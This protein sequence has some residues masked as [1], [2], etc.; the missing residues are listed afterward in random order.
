MSLLHDNLQSEND[1]VER[2]ASSSDGFD[3]IGRADIS[4]FNPGNILPEPTAVLGDITSWLK[5]T[6]YDHDGSEF[7]KHR[8]LRLAGTC[9]WVY[10]T[11]VY[12]QWHDGIDP[13]ILWI[14]GAPGSG[15]SVLAASLIEKLSQEECPVLYFF[16][17]HTIAANHSAEAAV[18][19]WLAQVLRFSPPLQVEL[20]KRIKG[21]LGDDAG[22][23]RLSLADAFRLLR[24]ALSHLPEAY[25]L[26]DALDEADQEALEPFL[27]H[28]DELSTWRPQEVKLIMTSRP[29]AVVE[30]IVRG[31][32]VLDVRLDKQRVGSDIAAYIQ[33]R[34]A[35]SSVPTQSRSRV[36]KIIMDRCD[37]LFLY[38]RLAMDHVLKRPYQEM[39]NSLRAIPAGL[40][41]VYSNILEE[42]CR[43]TDIPPGLQQLVLELVTHATRPL[44]LLEI[45]DCINAAR[46][47]GDLGT[48]KSLIRS[49]CGPLLE[50]LPD[51]TVHVIHHSLTEFLNGTVRDLGHST[52]P[53]FEP[54]STHNRLAL[55]CISYLQA[56]CLNSVKVIPEVRLLRRGH[57]QEDQVL[58]SFMRY[59][60]LNWHVHVQ[61][62]MLAGHDQS[63]ANKQIHA[64]FAK[65]SLEKLGRLAED[66][67]TCD[68]TP[69]GLATSFK[70]LSFAREVLCLAKLNPEANKV[71]KEPPLQHAAMNGDV[72]LV[73]LLLEFGADL[74]AY[75]DF[76]EST[77]HLAVRH[78]R[79]QVVRVLLDA[80]ADPFIPNGLNRRIR[81]KPRNDRKTYSP[82]HS[83]F[84]DGDFRIASMFIPYLKTAELANWALVKAVEHQRADILGRLL[85]N[86]MVNV[87]SKLR[88]WTPLCIACTN[89]DADSIDLLL[90]AGADPNILNNKYSRTRTHDEGAKTGRNALHA[91]ADS[92]ELKFTNSMK[93]RDDA[94]TRRCFKLVLDA[95]AKVDL[96]DHKGLTPLHV[97]TD[98]TAVGCLLDA[99]ADPDAINDAGETLLHRTCN[100][101]I[102]RALLPK[103]DID[104]KSQ[105][106]LTPLLA[107]LKELCPK[108]DL[109]LKKVSLLLEFRADATSVDDYGNGALHH[110]VSTSRWGRPDLL[111]LRKL[112]ASGADV[113]LKNHEGQTP[114]HWCLPG[115]WGG[116][117]G[118]RQDAKLLEELLAAGAEPEAKDSKGRTPL[119]QLMHSGSNYD[120]DERIEICE[121]MVAAGARIDT[122]DLEG[123]NLL[124][125]VLQAARPHLNLIRWLVSR[126]IN[127][128][129][130]DARGNTL[131]HLAAPA[132]AKTTLIN[133]PLISELGSLG[134]SPVKTNDN[135]QTPLHIVAGFHPFAFRPGSDRQNERQPHGY[136]A[137]LFDHLVGLYKNVDCVDNDG[138]TPL[139]IASTFSEYLTRRL[140]EKGADPRNKTLEGLTPLH[141][142]ARSRQSNTL[143]I[144]LSW[145]QANMDESTAMELLNARDCL[146][147]SALYY[148]C[149]SGRIETVRMLLDAGAT[150]E[151]ES[152]RGSPW[153]GCVALQDEDTAN[154]RLVSADMNYFNPEPDAAG[155]LI[156]DTLRRKLDVDPENYDW[157][158]PFP[159]ERLDEIIDLLVTHGPAS[160]VR[161]IDEAISWS[162]KKRF[163][164]AVECLLRARDRLGMKDEY[165]LD[166]E[167]CAHLSQRLET[168][169]PS[170]V[171]H[172]KDLAV[173]LM[174]DRRYALA[175]SEILRQVESL[176]SE[177]KL[178]SEVQMRHG[179]ILHCL[180]AGGFARILDQVTCSETVHATGVR[181]RR[182][183]VPLLIEACQ[184]EWCNMDVVRLLVET[185]GADPSAK[186][187]PLRES[188][189]G[190]MSGNGPT[191]LHVL[192]RGGHWWQV[193]KALPYLL[194]QGAD[195]EALDEYGLTPLNAA[196][197][198]IK[199]PKFSREAVE[200]LLQFGA[201]P[202]AANEEEQSCLSRAGGNMD[203]YQLLIRH[204]AVVSPSAMVDIIDRLDVT[205]L[206]TV[207][208]SGVDPNLRKPGKEVPS[209]T[210]MWLKRPPRVDPDRAVEKYPL[211]L[212]AEQ[213][214]YGS[215]DRQVSEKMLRLLLDHGANPS[216]RYAAS[217]VM[218]RLVDEGLIV[219][220]YMEGETKFLEILL[221]SPKLDL[222]AREGSFGRTLLLSAC[223]RKRD[224][225][226]RPT[227]PEKPTL[228]HLLLEAGADVRAKDSN[229]RT[230]LHIMLSVD[231][232]LG[233]PKNPD[234]GRIIAAA[235]ELVHAV[236]NEG[237]TPLHAAFHC[238]MDTRHVYDLI[239]AGADVQ[240]SVESTGNT[241]LHLLFQDTWVVGVDGEVKAGE[242]FDF[243]PPLSRDADAV[244]FESQGDIFRRLLALGIDVNARNHAGEAP[245]FAFFREA[246]VQVRMPHDGTEDMRAYSSELLGDVTL[247][248]QSEESSLSSEIR[249]NDERH[250]AEERAAVERERFVWQLFDDMGVDWTAVNCQGETLLH[251]VVADELY[252]RMEPSRRVRRFEFL[253]GKGVDPLMENKDHRTPLDVAADLEHEDILAL[254]RKS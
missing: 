76:G 11:A 101:D 43:R 220:A 227:E 65:E 136:D 118:N 164:H 196:L 195:V 238:G 142:A 172:D 209:T 6:G 190:Y 55:L 139:H 231:P 171:P 37:G 132:L 241:A 141:L 182:R 74:K 180:V 179:N 123:R 187:L 121:K 208:A 52:Y 155:V 205:L 21:G 30:K 244:Q 89:R 81:E 107:T 157:D 218:H 153:D 46:D 224:L 184:R 226:V 128:H 33:N 18:R 124:H 138:V 10:S 125:C 45:S 7:Q 243:Y 120:A 161:Y 8:S 192:V 106:G 75:D 159:H 40:S 156:A 78:G 250:R 137:C 122:T 88:S 87:N 149:A 72:A 185:K 108:A 66:S 62:A 211:H 104:V 160:G 91:L 47:M 84:R 116:T 39:D 131:W 253:M 252:E 77:L 93:T 41:V 14:R 61:K 145:L 114:L 12:R 127:P 67:K 207:L 174:A 158:F 105:S 198:L 85:D 119:C 215:G 246:R 225:N 57:L 69:L 168:P 36:A 254:F 24:T 58:P 86:P 133:L 95:G 221:E 223:S 92:C 212:L 3:L 191:A 170:T 56:G 97:A 70:L 28:F 163:Y 216:A 217:T 22:V 202:N 32:R 177:D 144:L 60:A 178:H 82:T 49:V 79:H 15:K 194:S 98:A 5:P 245:I 9:D 59:A 94:E 4:D 68:F 13:G 54:G 117:C 240:A 35:G 197:V 129:Q 186:A 63:E 90:K 147:R 193:N 64:M 219:S 17:R 113:N 53:V 2:Y 213:E 96:A 135:G 154:W 146:A 150:V 249:V 206:E 166:E 251:I 237:R 109:W 126:G 165:K 26:V 229:G 173:V 42:Q 234:V 222:E 103:A 34:L 239:E 130:T 230:A 242:K 169:L 228:I 102:L 71:V 38:A 203:I 110:L 1:H 167:T 143:G 204:G 183:V 188:L 235:P 162:A 25:I 31:V 115:L 134:V 248:S 176:L 247:L 232:Y 73:K 175:S 27:H 112:L 29:V 51:E 210:E 16:F 233:L 214:A 189:H 151:T 236:D 201:D 148:A 19:D 200:L 44:R 20:K 99:G 50:I 83:A 48:T 140:L 100:Y 111:L 23:E 152:Y 181:M 199:G 80:S